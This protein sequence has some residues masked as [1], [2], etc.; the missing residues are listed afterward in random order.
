MEEIFK[1]RMATGS[2]KSSKVS[3][4]KCLHETHGPLALNSNNNLLKRIANTVNRNPGVVHYV[5]KK[6]AECVDEVIK[7]GQ[8]LFMDEMKKAL[9]RGHLRFLISDTRAILSGRIGIENPH[10]S[11]FTCTHLTHL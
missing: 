11:R 7:L 6:I 4:E 3:T 10:R 9:V 2:N 8:R 5:E 1:R